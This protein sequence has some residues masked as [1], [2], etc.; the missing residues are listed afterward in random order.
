MELDANL[1]QALNNS[2]VINRG[3]IACTTGSCAP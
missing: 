3:S 1:S 2:Y